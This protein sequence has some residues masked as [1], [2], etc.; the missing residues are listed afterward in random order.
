MEYDN[1]EQSVEALAALGELTIG[2]NKV[3]VCHYG[4]QLVAMGNSDLPEDK[5]VLECKYRLCSV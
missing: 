4:H 2:E 3:A 1:A 5:R